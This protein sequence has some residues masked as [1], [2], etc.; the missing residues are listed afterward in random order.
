MIQGAKTPAEVVRAFDQLGISVA[1][2]HKHGSDL[3]WMLARCPRA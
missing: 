2:V 3:D 1:D